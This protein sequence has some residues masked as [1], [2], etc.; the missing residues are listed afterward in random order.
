MRFKKKFSFKNKNQIWRLLIAESENG[1]LIVETRDTLSDSKEVYYNCLD[2]NSGKILFSDLQLDEKSWIGIETIYKDVIL[3]HQYAIPNMPGHKRIIAFDINSQKV[4]WQNDEFVFRF[5]YEDI[6]YASFASMLGE[7]YFALDLQTGD[8]KTPEGLPAEEVLIKS[9]LAAKDYSNYIFP[10][11][12]EPFSD[13]FEKIHSLLEKEIGGV[14][15]NGKIEFVQID[16]TVLANFHL[17][18]G[19][20]SVTNKFVAVDKGRNKTIF[21]DLLNK[22]AKTYVPDSFFVYKNLLFLL[23]EKKE[24]LVVELK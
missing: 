6:V 1:K 24:V 16:K 3:F 14:N 4:I 22:S 19:A 5:V 8:I 2:L 9:Q 23:K 21:S 10:E 11:I 7:K 13:D 18:N 15:I 12:L 20:D 17:E